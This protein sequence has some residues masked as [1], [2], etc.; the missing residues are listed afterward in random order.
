[1]VG[2]AAFEITEPLLEKMGLE[3]AGGS[4]LDDVSQDGLVVDSSVD[5]EGKPLP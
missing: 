5:A 2:N 3:E 4:V 1:V